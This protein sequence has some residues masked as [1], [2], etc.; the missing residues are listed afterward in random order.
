M[1]TVLS[2]KSTLVIPK[3]YLFLKP[4]LHPADA[5]HKHEINQMKTISYASKNRETDASELRK[6]RICVAFGVAVLYLLLLVSA[7]G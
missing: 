7:K 6:F 2:A 5:S 4:S 3:I 1:F